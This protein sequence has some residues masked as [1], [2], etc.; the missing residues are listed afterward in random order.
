MSETM[1]ERLVKFPL[2]DGCHAD[3]RR[4]FFWISSHD[5]IAF[6]ASEVALAM[7]SREASPELA[8]AEDSLRWGAEEPAHTID[9]A[10]AAEIRAVMAELDRLRAELAALR[11]EASRRVHV[12]GLDEPSPEEAIHCV[13]EGYGYCHTAGEARAEFPDSPVYA[14]TLTARK[15]EP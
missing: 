11:G 4:R 10:S 1:K 3:S 8:E 14:V 13:L 2:P 7:A 15:V 5:A 6:A 9:G 12:S